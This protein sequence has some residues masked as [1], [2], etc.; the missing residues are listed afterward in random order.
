MRKKIGLRILLSI[1]VLALSLKLIAI[2]FVEPWIAHKIESLSGQ[3]TAPFKIKVEDVNLFLL[4]FGIGFNH[5]TIYENT[6]DAVGT[7]ATGNIDFVQFKGLNIFKVFFS[8]ELVFR[9]LLVSNGNIENKVSHSKHSPHPFLL[10]FK[11][12][13]QAIHLDHVDLKLQ[14]KLSSRTYL[15]R[16][17]SFD[18]RDFI[19]LKG[20]KPFS[21]SSTS[22]ELN[23]PQLVV[24]STDSMYTFLVDRI[25][26]STVTEHLAID[27]FIIRPNY[28]EY[29][30][31][32]REKYQIDR[33]EGSFIH[34]DVYGFCMD[35]FIK[36]GDIVFREAIVRNLDMDIFRDRRKPFEHKQKPV[37]QDI[38]EEYAHTID[39]DSIHLLNGNIKYAE[40]AKDA[41]HPGIV[42]FKDAT[43]SIYTISNDT[44][45]RGLNDT[46]IMRAE[47]MLYGKGKL[48]VRVKAKLFEPHHTFEMNGRLGPMLAKALN[49]ILEKNAFLY[50]YGKINSLSFNFI[51]NQN[52]SSGSVLFL[53]NDLSITLKN[54]TS[55]DTSGLKEQVLTKVANTIMI[56]D[57]PTQD[58]PTR[59]GTISYQRDPEKMFFNYSLK[60]VLSGIKPSVNKAAEKKKK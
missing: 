28:K 22:F 57:N 24:T 44:L 47:A 16:N 8:H 34:N 19:L 30:F 48:R 37:F 25:S 33:I 38:L 27:S 58:E 26:Y 50:A 9:E 35:D 59:R 46:L 21:F 11:I 12:S 17:S 13:I 29:D 2:F 1:V 6:K 51:A 40:H 56:D 53:Y 18:F 32:S 4:S 36:Y 31:T 14:D 39:V 23:C 10:P 45:R 49:P 5:I 7:V 55:D 60:S 52:S 43:A 41:N 54:K 20:E 3:P 15:I 42:R